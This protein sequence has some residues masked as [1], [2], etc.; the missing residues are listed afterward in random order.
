M[1]AFQFYCLFMSNLVPKEIG[2]QINY[3][4]EQ[5]LTIYNSSIH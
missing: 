1:H 4:V 3:L 2:L 5:L